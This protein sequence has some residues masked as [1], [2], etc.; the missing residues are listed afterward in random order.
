MLIDG[1]RNSVMTFAFEMSAWKRSPSWNV[2]RAVTPAVSALRRQL[3]HLRVELDADRPRAALGGRDD[4]TPVARPEVHVEVLWRELRH[5]KHLVD[6]RLRRRD[7]HD[8][9]AGLSDLRLERLLGRLLRPRRRRDEQH[10]RNNEHRRTERVQSG[11][12]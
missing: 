12:S 6:K 10:R 3:D 9:L 4:G 1:S 5:V 8:V 7:P 2:A 11:H